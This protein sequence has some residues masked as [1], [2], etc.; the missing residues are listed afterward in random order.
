MSEYYECKSCG[1]VVQGFVA[2]QCIECC[3]DHRYKRIDPIEYEPIG[4]D[5]H[6]AQVARE[7]EGCEASDS[8]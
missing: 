5:H 2:M 6:L 3:D 7:I 4:T 8:G 1:Q